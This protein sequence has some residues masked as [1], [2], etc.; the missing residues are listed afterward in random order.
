MP[1]SVHPCPTRVHSS[2]TRLRARAAVGPSR[3][4]DDQ[5]DPDGDQ[6]GPDLAHR[7]PSLSPLLGTPA[8][9]LG[10]VL[11][12]QPVAEVPRTRAEDE[13]TEEAE[14]PK[15]EDRRRAGCPR[16]ILVYGLPQP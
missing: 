5:D 6:E 4:V 9:R 8:I 1:L 13:T 11:V 3:R 10:V 16:K 15:H 14:G 2:T 12:E 7:Y